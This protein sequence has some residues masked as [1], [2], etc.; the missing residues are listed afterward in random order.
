MRHNIS[1]ATFLGSLQ[2]TTGRPVS[3]SAQF[4]QAVAPLLGKKPALR[5][6]KNRTPGDNG[7]SGAAMQVTS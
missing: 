5:S 4:N 7:P 3:D 2:I 6:K 1:F